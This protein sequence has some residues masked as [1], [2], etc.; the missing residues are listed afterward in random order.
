MSPSPTDRIEKQIVLRAPRSR[1]W[2]AIA[3][4]E[5][6][7]TWFGVKGLKGWFEPG[8]RV[9]GQIAS[10]GHE[11]LTLELTVEEVEPERLLSWRWHPHAVEPGVDYSSEPTTR[12]EFRLED[13]GGGTRLTLVES[14]FDGIPAQRRDQAF[15]MNGEGWAEQLRRVERHVSA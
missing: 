4:A 8:Q 13:D 3:N 1:V 14:G 5:E 9:R 11:H 10:E 7:G 6:L 15:G 2:K 12:V